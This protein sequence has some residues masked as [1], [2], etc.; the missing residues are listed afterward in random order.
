[1]AVGLWYSY[2]FW[3]TC[4]PRDDT[5]FSFCYHSSSWGRRASVI[6]VVEKWRRGNKATVCKHK[7]VCLSA[8]IKDSLRMQSPKRALWLVPLEWDASAMK[9]EARPGVGLAAVFPE[10]VLLSAYVGF[11]PHGQRNPITESECGWKSRDACPSECHIK[12]G[13]YSYPERRCCGRLASLALNKNLP[14]HFKWHGSS[15]TACPYCHQDVIFH[16]E[17]PDHRDRALWWA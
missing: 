11:S 16:S 9:P 7:L 10:A 2:I 14:G 1:M 15:D 8:G 4:L 5:C 17:K 12:C 6:T 3:P 13:G